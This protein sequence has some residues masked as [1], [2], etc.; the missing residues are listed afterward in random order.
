M[1]TYHQKTCIKYTVEIRVL[2]FTLMVLE[3]RY[4]DFPLSFYTYLDKAAY[5]ALSVLGMLLSIRKATYHYIT[6]VMLLR[7]FVPRT[8]E[9]AFIYLMKGS[10][11]SSTVGRSGSRQTV[12][13]GL[14]CVY[15]GEQTS[16]Q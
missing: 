11:C 15:S 4:Y 6:L 14:G 16:M 10:G 2:Q 8:S 5:M 1:K 9:T 7:R 12:S 13:L 3:S